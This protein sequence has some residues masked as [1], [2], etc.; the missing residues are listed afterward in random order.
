MKN[1]L[2]VND[3]GFP[4]DVNNTGHRIEFIREGTVSDGC[5]CW[6]CCRARDAVKPVVGG[7]GVVAQGTQ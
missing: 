5:C 4:N 2:L 3:L 1:A 6:W 7:G